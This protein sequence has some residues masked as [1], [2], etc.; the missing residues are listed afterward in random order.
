MFLRQVHRL[1]TLMIHIIVYNLKR[2]KR[3]FI[4]LIPFVTLLVLYLIAKS[5][6]IDSIRLWDCTIYKYT[7]ICCPGCGMTRAVKA[8]FH[9]DILLSLRQNAFLIISILIVILLYIEFVFKVFN[10]HILLIPRNKYFWII[11]GIFCFSYS[12]LRNF[13]VFIFYPPL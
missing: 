3:V 5:G 8:L 1:L 9:G 11:F 10:K 6:V 12:V 2:Y 13:S 7:H 4:I